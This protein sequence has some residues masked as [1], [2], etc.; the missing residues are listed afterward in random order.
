MVLTSMNILISFIF[1]MTYIRTTNCNTG[2]Y[3]HHALTS[4]FYNGDD[5]EQELEHNG[6]LLLPSNNLKSFSYNG[7]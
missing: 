7:K 2:P 5:Y 1:A 4:D 3:L 6:R